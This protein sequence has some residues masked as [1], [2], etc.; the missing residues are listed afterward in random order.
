ML[1]ELKE[2][3]KELERIDKR[4]QRGSYEEGEIQERIDRI[5]E[6]P[7]LLQS[8]QQCVSL[9]EQTDHNDVNTMQNILSDLD[10]T[11]ASCS[12]H[13]EMVREAMRQ[14]YIQFSDDEIDE[15]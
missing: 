12:H 5:S 13:I 1:Y 3:L 8:L 7:R 10:T 9:L 15:I 11:L 4:L 6:F 2:T 14:F